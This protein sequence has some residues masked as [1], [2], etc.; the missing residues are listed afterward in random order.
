MEKR[1]VWLGWVPLV[2]ALV[3]GGTTAVA[4]G[5]FGLLHSFTG[6][7]NDGASPE[8]TP[9]LIGSNLYGVTFNGG[10][11]SLGTIYRVST[12]GTGFSLLFSFP[13]GANGANPFCSLVNT[14]AAFY[15]MT[16]N[17]GVNDG[18]VVFG[19]NTNG[20]SYSVVHTFLGGNNDGL[21]PFGS[22]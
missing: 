9:L 10:S 7:T 22:L 21:F 19:L 18:G 12:N 15:G 4:Q 6:A 11:S 1:R 8:G 20:P 17:G 16:F 14:G 5:G 2:L 13:G 3:L